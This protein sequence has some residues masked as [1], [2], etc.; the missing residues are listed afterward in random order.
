MEP[1]EARNSPDIGL[2]LRII[3]RVSWCPEFAKYRL[4]EGDS[5]HQFGLDEVGDGDERSSHLGVC[6]LGIAHAGECSV[7]IDSEVEE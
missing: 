1:L 3:R 4:G 7:E 5:A 6:G 2:Y